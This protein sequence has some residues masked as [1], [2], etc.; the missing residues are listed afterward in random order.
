MASYR[1]AVRRDTAANWTS[2]DPILAQGEFG[3]ESDTLL[4]KIGDGVTAWSALGYYDPNPAL[5][6]GGSLVG[7]FKYDNGYPVS[8]AGRFGFNSTTPASI[9]AL[10]ISVISLNDFVWTGIADRVLPLGSQFIAIQKNDSTRWVH[11]Q[12]DSGFTNNTTHYTYTVSYVA[13]GPGGLP[14]NGKECVIE[15]IQP[16]TA[17]LDDLGDVI[18]TTPTAGDQIKYNGSEW[19]N[20]PEPDAEIHKQYK[21]DGA[22]AVNTGTAGIIVPEDCNNIRATG[23]LDTASSSGNVG[24]DILVN[25]V[26]QLTLSVPQGLTA[27]STGTN[28]L[29][30]NKGD[31]ITVDITNAGTGADTLYVPIELTR[32]G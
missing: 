5:G 24:V 14:D 6:T 15:I 13:N 27:G 18:I 30:L 21:Y 22:L 9:T 29:T 25:G 12:I 20:V 4:L 16:V 28:S 3:Y 11:V 1:L 8:S 10:D 7:A 26:V 2:A 31:K 17:V 23:Y 19:V 32:V